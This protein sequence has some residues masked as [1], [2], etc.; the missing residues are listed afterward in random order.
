MSY[1]AI[2]TYPWDLAEIG[3]ATAAEQFHKLNLDTVTV[4]G[5]YHAGKFLRP[6]GKNGKVFFP[7][8]GTVYFTP[9]MTR[10]GAIKPLANSIVG[11]FD[12]I[13]ELAKSGMAVNA[14]M[15][16][17][18]NSRLGRS[19]PEACVRNA[20]GDA[21]VYSL[22]PSHP[23]ARAYAVALIDDMTNRYPVSGVSIETPGYLPYAHG[24]HH[25]F[26]LLRH[27]RWLDNLLGLDFSPSA[28]TRA[29]A[30]G[31]DAERLRRQVAS[32]ITAY[33]AD[34]VN[35]P[36]DMA[37][38]FWLADTQADGDLRRLLDFRN[39]EVTSLV[40][41]I[42]AAARTDATI[43]II[44]SVARPTAGAWYEGSDLAAL[45]ATVGIIE[46][47][48]YEP[49]ANRIA[50]DLFDLKRR[51]R[52]QGRIR[53]IL[54]PAYPDHETK[55]DFLASIHALRAGGV[56][57]FAFYNWGHVREANLEWIAEAMQ[58]AS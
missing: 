25:E 20:F 54:R 5:S 35:F 14:W 36:D 53:A 10:Y 46:A 12:A 27:N 26:S 48:F 55:G 31:I 24:Y 16:L 42:K 43:S 30:S 2:Y 29:N 4:A 32:D 23:E 19:H 37:E 39:D 52:G 9:D 50:S 45:A 28:M 1:K 38:A 13:A 41:R 3:A 40:T 22:S 56:E 6:H 18:H 21:Y 17:L 7:E 15:V 57:E 34:G 8:D 11:Q 51:L 44:P 49:D 47:C 58:S 33:L